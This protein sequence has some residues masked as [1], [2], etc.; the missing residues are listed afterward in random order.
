MIIFNKKI[1]I[2]KC[3]IYLFF[4]I[5]WNIFKDQGL[6]KENIIFYNDTIEGIE[7]KMISE[8]SI[9]RECGWRFLKVKSI[10]STELVPFKENEPKNGQIM[11]E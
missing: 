7:N 11:R 10:H 2:Y 4:F 6:I 1:I 5:R 9:I 8:F 3:N